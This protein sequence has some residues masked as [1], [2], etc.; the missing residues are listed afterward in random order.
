MGFPEAAE[1]LGEAKEGEHFA[2]SPKEHWRQI[3]SNNSL[4]RLNREIRRRR[5]VMGIFSNREA[6]VRLVDA[7]LAE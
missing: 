4:K 6:V 7:V 5:D 3:R 2:T 1:M